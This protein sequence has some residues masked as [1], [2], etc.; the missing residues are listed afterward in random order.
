LNVILVVDSL[1]SSRLSANSPFLTAIGINNPIHKQKIALKAMDVVLFGAAKKHNYLKDALLCTSVILAIGGLWFAYIQNKYSQSHL[2][3]MMRDMDSL[4]K[5][6]QQLTSLQQELDKAKQDQE[7]VVMEKVNLEKK[8]K[9]N[10]NQQMI[11]TMSYTGLSDTARV[12]ELEE[13]LKFVREE[14]RRAESK[15]SS[16]PTMSVPLQQWL[17]LTYE[18]ELKN[19]NAKRITAEFQLMAA[20]EGVI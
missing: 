17:Q 1:V 4:S 7:S 5:A 20:K 3:K 11:R 2:K 9:E 12:A 13:E 19:Y 10:E 8:L 16:K 6:E 15:V 18:L 14:L